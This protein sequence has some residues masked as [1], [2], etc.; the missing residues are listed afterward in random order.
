MSEVVPFGKYKGQP[1]EALAAD[2]GYLDWLREQ[3]WFQTRYPNLHTIII[4]NFREPDETP[5]HN[6]LQAAFLDEGFQRRVFVA[7]RPRAYSDMRSALKN[8]IQDRLRDLNHSLQIHAGELQRYESQRGDGLHKDEWVEERIAKSTEVV[9]VLMAAMERTQ[10]I[11]PEDLAWSFGVEFEAKGIDVE[12]TVEAWATM[13]H[14]AYYSSTDIQWY[15][16]TLR[17]WT[18]KIELKPTLG[19]DYPAVLRQMRASGSDVLMVGE[20]H[21]AAIN[22][23]QLTKIFD[24]AGCRVIMVTQV[25]EIGGSQMVPATAPES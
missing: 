10:A 22:L 16:D 5:E 18:F 17:S 9:K 6:R 3:P 13:P 7:L 4:N 20:F 21:S 23:E 15:E 12:L 2:Q 1:I 25:E 11:V 19:D 24:T 8:R 14:L